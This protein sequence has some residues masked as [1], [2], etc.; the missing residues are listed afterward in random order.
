MPFDIQAWVSSSFDQSQAK[1]RDW[2][3]TN[4][5]PENMDRIAELVKVWNTLNKDR[6]TTVQ[7]TSF[8]AVH[9]MLAILHDLKQ[10]TEIKPLL[11]DAEALAGACERLMRSGCGGG[12]DF[13][14]SVWDA[15][16]A[17]A[18]VALAAWR[19]KYPKE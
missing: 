12:S 11:P 7:L 1:M 17:G 13:G 15:A 5:R 18:D 6:E 16:C 8:F 2:C 19:A 10:E 9:G 4:M 14:D 3:L